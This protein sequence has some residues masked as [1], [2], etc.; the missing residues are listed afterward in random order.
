MAAIGN[1][2]AVFYETETNRTMNKKELVHA[3]SKEMNEE[4]SQEKIRAVLDTAVSV[5]SRTLNEG[6][7]VKFAGFGSLVPKERPPRRYYDPKSKDCTLSEGK[8]S[9]VFVSSRKK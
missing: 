8:R 1:M 6:E 4:I 9:I 2:V 3:I 7:A 5:I